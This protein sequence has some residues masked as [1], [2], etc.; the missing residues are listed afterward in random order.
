MCTNLMERGKTTNRLG[1]L[2]I[3]FFIGYVGAQMGSA[4]MISPGDST[5]PG[6]MSQAEMW[7][8]GDVGCPMMSELATSVSRILSYSDDINLS[9]GQVDQL[10]SIRDS[11]QQDAVKLYA[12]LRAAMLELSNDIENEEI[13]M[14]AIRKANGEIEKNQAELRSRNIEV[15]LKSRAVLTNDQIQELRTRGLWNTL[16]LPWHQGMMQQ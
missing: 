9:P 8:I 4:Q 13:D 1:I 5:M 10:K 12:N 6:M 11:Y 16:V 3:V 7:R 14:N 15:F 2:I